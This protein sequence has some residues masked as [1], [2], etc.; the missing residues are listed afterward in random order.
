MSTTSSPATANGARSH[1]SV[2]SDINGE[3]EFPGLVEIAGQLR[4]Q[5]TASS[6]VVEETAVVE[7]ELSAKSIQVKG[8]VQ[9]KLTGAEVRLASSARVSG[10]IGYESLSIDSGAEVNAACKRNA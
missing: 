6:I 10:D 2:G 3:L 1:L 7:G 8:R 4:G 9:G 5:V